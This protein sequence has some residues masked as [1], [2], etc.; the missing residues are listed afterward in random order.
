MQKAQKF[1]L[2]NKRTPYIDFKPARLK[3]HSNDDWIV[4]FYWKPINSTAKMKRFR[5]RIKYMTNTNERR[6]YAN[7]K[8]RHINELLENG[9]SPAED[10]M[11]FTGSFI[12]VLDNY[13]ASLKERL[14][15]DKLR[16][17]TYRTYDSFVRNTKEYMKL[18]KQM[19]INANGFNRKFVN[20]YIHYKEFTL[21]SSNRTINN[22]ISFMFTLNKYMIDQEITEYNVVSNIP[23]RKIYKKKIRQRIPEP[24]KKEIF[25]HLKQRHPAY[26]T[27]CLMTYLCFV[28]RTEISKLRVKDVDLAQSLLTVPGEISKSKKDG[29]VTLPDQYVIILADHIKYADPDQWLFSMDNFRPGYDQLEPRRIS[30]FW[31]RMRTKLNIPKVYQFYSLKDTG[32][33]EHF[34]KGIPAIKIR[35]QARHENIS[36][37]EMYAPKRETADETI[38]NIYYK[39]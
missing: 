35:N 25:D 10:K 32:I 17:D 4:V 26:Y 18:S 38:R 8:I 9:W 1:Q 13:M 34:E 5:R 36:T 29:Y 20:G 22:L 37:T 24:I 30:D 31:Y 16:Y 27:L 39:L 33:T 11:T 7:L 28:R 15:N 12:D 14:D 23:K 19:T 3:E 21:K 2:P 6:K